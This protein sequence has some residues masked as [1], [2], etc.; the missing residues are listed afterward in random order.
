MLVFA[1]AIVRVWFARA[2]V[3]IVIV[4][5][6]DAAA[7]LVSMVASSRRVVPRPPHPGAHPSREARALP[8]GEDAARRAIHRGRNVYL[9]AY[10][11]YLR[12]GGLLEK[13]STERSLGKLVAAALPLIYGNRRDSYGKV[14]A[15]R[16]IKRRLSPAIR[17]WNES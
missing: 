17:T 13:R 1:V 4:I 15:A 7:R 11:Y 16:S 3:V 12:K 10:A 2:V 9:Q 8:R 14:T 6:V 5:A